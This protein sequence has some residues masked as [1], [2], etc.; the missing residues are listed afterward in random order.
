[1]PVPRHRPSTRPASAATG[2]PIGGTAPFGHPEPVPVLLDRDLLGFEEVWAAAG[3]PDTVF[4]VDPHR[5][6]E[7]TG[8]PA[9]DVAA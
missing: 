2:Y 5:L 4:P 9:A 7:A 6:Q 1:V 3:T 8:A